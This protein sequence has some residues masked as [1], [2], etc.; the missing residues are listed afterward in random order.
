MLTGEF[1][2]ERHSHISSQWILPNSLPPV[3][4]PLS[5]LSQP[6][7]YMYTCATGIIDHQ[8]VEESP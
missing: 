2:T 3:S 4:L 7:V 8:S 6:F 1:L 5:P